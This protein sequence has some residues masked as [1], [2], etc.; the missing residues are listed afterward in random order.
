MST[1]A[2]RGVLTTTTTQKRKKSR[3]KNLQ[4]TIA[5]VDDQC[6]HGAGRK[7]E[8]HTERVMRLTKNREKTEENAK[9]QTLS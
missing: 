2:D 6:K 1:E 8:Q 4:G 7:Q 9:I 5:V 3:S